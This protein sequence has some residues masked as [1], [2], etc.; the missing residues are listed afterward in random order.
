MFDNRHSL[1]AEPF[2]RPQATLA[3]VFEFDSSSAQFCVD[4]AILLSLL[5]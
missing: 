2:V 4:L 3:S 5:Y 1:A